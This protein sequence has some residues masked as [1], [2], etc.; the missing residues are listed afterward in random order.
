MAN[1]L[2][3]LRN[4]AVGFID[5]LGVFVRIKIAQEQH[6]VAFCVIKG[7]VQQTMVFNAAD[8]VYRALDVVLPYFST[9]RCAAGVSGSPGNSVEKPSP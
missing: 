6:V 7:L 1:T 8:N 4:G 2:N 5:W 9:R 3:L